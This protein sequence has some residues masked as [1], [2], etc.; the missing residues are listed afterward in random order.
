MI[1]RGY[2][3][4][5][6]AQ[7]VA[8]VARIW[9]NRGVAGSVLRSA[10]RCLD[11]SLEAMIGPT[12]HCPHDGAEDALEFRAISRIFSGASPMDCA[13]FFIPSC[14]ETTRFGASIM[15]GVNATAL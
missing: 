11:V 4:V 9:T 7:T 12:I 5:R 8:V 14:F 6:G 2:L 1:R 3:E 10:W 15:G 13:A